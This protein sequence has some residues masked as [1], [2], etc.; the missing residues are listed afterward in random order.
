MKPNLTQM[1][2]EFKY[3]RAVHVT[4]EPYFFVQKL[5]H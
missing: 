3:L 1:K 4:L 5:I 2:N